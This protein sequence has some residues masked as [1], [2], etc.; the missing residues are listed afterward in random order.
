M[1]HLEERFEKLIE[2]VRTYIPNADADKIHL[3]LTC[4]TQAHTGQKRKD[5][6]DYVTHPIAVAEI[7]ADIATTEPMERSMFPV[8]RI[9][10]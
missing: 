4:A 7:I 10:P 5:G 8:I 1:K 2:K 3:A 9:T 6:T